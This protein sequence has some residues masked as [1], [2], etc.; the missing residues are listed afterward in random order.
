MAMAQQ[1]ASVP[2]PL[3]I[4]VPLTALAGALAVWWA[5][6]MSV[7]VS[8]PIT[9][10]LAVVVVGGG[11]LWLFAP[12]TGF[13]VLLS[14]GAITAVWSAWGLASGGTAPWLLTAFWGG[15]AALLAALLHIAIRA[16]SPERSA[17]ATVGAVAVILLLS[18]IGLGQYIRLQWTDAERAVL[19]D[20]LSR[21]RRPMTLAIDAAPRGVWASRWSE[22]VDPDVVVA[23]L[24][25]ELTAAG[26][27][28]SRSAD[29]PEV[30]L[31]AQ[32]D[33]Y[34]CQVSAEPESAADVTQIEVLAYSGE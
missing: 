26:W 24:S 10:V 2:A 13:W 4:A 12:R 18:A 21:D 15:C 27:R 22:R 19:R 25:A 31:Y 5:G 1:L 28:V 6:A 33:Q 11:I 32:K 23:R 20:I 16:D 3:R 7:L 8:T 17:W 30:G 14:A 9:S 34:R 29:G